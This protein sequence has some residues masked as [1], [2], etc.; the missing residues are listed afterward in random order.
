[1]TVFPRGRTNSDA[2]GMSF[3]IVIGMHMNHTACI[4]NSNRRVEKEE[5]AAENNKG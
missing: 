4:V 3:D 5:E 1:M 2:V